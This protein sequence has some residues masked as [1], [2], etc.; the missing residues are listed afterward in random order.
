LKSKKI[1]PRN[2]Q[3]AEVRE[4]SNSNWNPGLDPGPEKIYNSE[5]W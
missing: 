3:I 1:S 2:C 5:N 4:K